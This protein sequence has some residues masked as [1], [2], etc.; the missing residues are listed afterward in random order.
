MP[1]RYGDTDLPLTAKLA[2]GMACMI[3]GLLARTL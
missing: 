3:A 2:L 1:L